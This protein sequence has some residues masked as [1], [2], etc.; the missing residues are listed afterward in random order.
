MLL[1]KTDSEKKREIITICLFLLCVVLSSMNFMGKYFYC[2]Y[3]GAVF[4]F[5]FRNKTAKLPVCVAFFALFLF[6]VCADIFSDPALFGPEPTRYLK[7]F[8]FPL[9]FAM[10]YNYFKEEEPLGLS[11]K[12]LILLVSCV[13]G[14]GLIHIMLNFALHFNLHGTAVDGRS[15]VDFWS[16]QIV[17]ATIQAALGCVFIGLAAAWIFSEAKLYKKIVAVLGLAIFFGYNLILAGRMPIALFF[18]AVFA[19]AVLFFSAY[20]GPDSKKYKIRVLCA[21]LLLAFSLA[22]IC[23]FNIANLKTTIVHS[24]LY[25]RFFG[26]DSMGL[27]EDTRLECKAAYLSRL[28]S[29]L[30][31]GGNIYKETGVHAHDLYLDTWDVTGALSALAIVVYCVSSFINSAR[32]IFNRNHSFEARQIVFCVYLVL[33]VQFLFEPIMVGLPWLFASL[34]LIDG[35]IARI[36]EKTRG[37]VSE[38]PA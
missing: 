31:G 25:Q 23:I 20:R 13:A 2:V 15:T 5:A 16:R 32:F 28:F 10:G 14:G 37:P 4:L 35:Y 6:A 12:K 8:A 26:R 9:I 19:A 18:L 30:T 3:T 27:T 11:D 34:C 33:H 1:P 22:L 29:H 24:P 21:V 38:K 7:P 36:N 17:S